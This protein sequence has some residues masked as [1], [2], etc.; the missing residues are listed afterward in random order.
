STRN[1]FDIQLLPGDSFKDDITVFNLS[2]D[3][4]LPLRIE[5]SLWDI[6]EDSDDIEF[7]YSEPALNA[8]SWFSLETRDIV[9][10][11]DESRSV[12][13]DINVPKDV[14]PGSYLVMMRFQPQLALDSGAVS[15]IPEL[16]V[17]F[18]IQI[19]LLGLEQDS[20][21]YSATIESFD[22]SHAKG[23]P[24][25][26]RA[27]A[28]IYEDMA[29]EFLAKVKNNGIYHFKTSGFI[30]IKNMFGTTVA[31]AELPEKYLLPN[32]VRNIEIQ[33][34]EDPSF[35]KRLLQVGPYSAVMVLNVPGQKDPLLA[36]MGFF[37]FPWKIILA[38]AWALL[39][40]F[41]A[42]RRVIGSFSALF[43]R[44]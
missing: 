10:Q 39:V 15:T 41:F 6:N 14:S 12:A 1:I 43:R 7:V 29:Q 34:Q 16:G 22:A 2:K 31:R 3:I 37:A 27:R 13:F 20:P 19:S 32:R 24:L 5:L 17:L 26:S 11:P 25:I 18:F 40:A 21:L 33:V 23:V 30:E 44:T 35:W 38:S 42:R 28:G 8:S 36:T 9:L 4:A